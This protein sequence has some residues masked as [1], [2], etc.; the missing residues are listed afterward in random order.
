MDGGPL[1]FPVV[2]SALPIPSLPIF[3]DMGARV[4]LRVHPYP[5]GLPWEDAG[6]RGE[7]WGLLSSACH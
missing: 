1:E 3:L 2:L 5:S 7:W 6:Q 4:E